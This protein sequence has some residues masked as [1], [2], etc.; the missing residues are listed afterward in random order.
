[1]PVSYDLCCLSSGVTEISCANSRAVSQDREMGGD[2]KFMSLPSVVTWFTPRTVTR[3]GAVRSTPLEHLFDLLAN[4]TILA[5]K[6]AGKNGL[7][8]PE[9]YLKYPESNLYIFILCISYTF[10]WSPP[11]SLQSG[12]LLHPSRI[13]CWQ[14]G[15]DATFPLRASRTLRWP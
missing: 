4:V 8:D 1:M 10:V 7:K 12:I 3:G 2:Y 9:V 5:D 15:E 13:Y 11:S 6:P 14:Q